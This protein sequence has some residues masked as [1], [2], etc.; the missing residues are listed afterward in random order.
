MFISLF[1]NLL[2][3]FPLW[4][5]WKRGLAN[6]AAL[7]IAGGIL[8][9]PAIALGA[10][11]EASDLILFTN[12]ER[13]ALKLPELVPNH[14]LT[15]AARAKA[16]DLLE[17]SYFS[18]TTPQ[19]K[20][21]YEWIEEAGYRYLYAGEN[22]AID[23]ADSRALMAAWMKSPTHRANIVN[24]H[25]TD[26][27]IVALRGAWD[28]RETTVVVQL[29]GS[30]LTDAPTVLGQAFENASAGLGLRRES[31]AT[32]AAD[33][34]LLPSLA[35]NR[36]FDVMVRPKNT[37]TLAASNLSPQAI[38]QVPFTKIVQNETYQTLL[39][40]SSECCYP[41][42]A[43]A[44]TEERYGALASTPIS[45]P[46]LAY[47]FSRVAGTASGALPAFPQTLATN[48]AIAGI[49]A[50]LLLAAFE[51]E[52]RREFLRLNAKR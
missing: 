30:L 16:A 47:V 33:L 14:D 32:L 28:N 36:Y 20:P 48:L 52:I 50:L 41:E 3:S 23:F 46:T 49:A 37:A 11:I 39:K 6:C 35:G 21:F 25:Y 2:L 10:S 15:Q 27:G 12:Q 19:G 8:F 17:Q 4:K 9:A 1:S 45:Y 18:H 31:L 26:I 34:V 24:D 5:L 29:F 7:S 43:F 38:A 13:K 42:T 44:L 22:L 51:A 40:A